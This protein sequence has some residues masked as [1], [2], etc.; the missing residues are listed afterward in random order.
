MTCN[1]AQANL[2]S[3]SQVEDETF[4]DKSKV[5]DSKVGYTNRQVR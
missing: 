1:Y 2:L 4:T 3:L 5:G